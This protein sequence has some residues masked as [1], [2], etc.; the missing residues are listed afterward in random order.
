MLA[1][2]LLALAA[3]HAACPTRPG[4]VLELLGRVETGGLTGKLAR[5]VEAATGRSFE[6]HDLGIV[7]TRT[8]FDGRL[9]WSQD[10]SGGV[11][12][13]NSAFGRR[14]AASMAWLDGRVGCSPSQRDGITRLG[15]RTE[16]K[17]R[18]YAWKAGP[19]GGVPFELWY[20][21][22][23]GRLDRPFFQ[24]AETRLIRHF[25][26]WRSV[27]G[28]L[29]PFLQRDEFPEDEDEVV[30]RI[31]HA[32]I[33]KT[34]GPADFVRP[35]PPSDARILGHV[36]F[37]TVPFEDDHRTRIYLPVT[38]NGK[39]PFLFELDNGG[40]NILTSETAAALGLQKTGSFNATGAGTAVAQSG[41]ARVTRVQIGNAVVTD[42]PFSVREFSA[43][44]NDRSP[45][46]PRAGV[47]GL[48]LF[49]RFVIAI[50]P[51][52]K[53]V[54]L[55][56]FDTID[57][58]ATAPIPLVFTEDAPLIEGSYDGEP[59]D[60]MLDTGNAGPTIIEDYWA[61]PRGLTTEL[62]KGVARGATKV[63]H[64][65]VGVGPFDLNDELVSYYGPAERGSEYSRAVAGIY[66]EPLLSRFKS[67]YDY[68]GGVVWLEPLPEVKPQPFDRS[69]LSLAKA[70]GGA[71]KVAPVAGGS[72]AQKAGIAKDD[73]IGA[74][75]GIPSTKLSRA[76]AAAIFR[77]EPG[78][79][80][81][82]T[83]TFGGAQGLKQL[84]LAEL[85]SR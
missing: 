43:A 53:T 22:R 49:E 85:I 60:F 3:A 16:G 84:T 68:S 73:L 17:R 67:T 5:R 1:A 56:R 69:G 80:V 63:T 37:T 29:V 58:P 51:R 4:E 9:A 77:G 62:N 71:L 27:D 38:L 31:T 23:G 70:E 34:A 55:S 12:D 48:E 8:G 72:P 15:V 25:A 40:H 50:D 66:G 44:S 35:R 52:A 41:T 26:D 47:L 10:G 45:N 42:Q 74:I 21:L 18:F 61:V 7:V 33:R 83:G 2:A 30:R 39:G 75:Q 79:A 46:P 19:P 76:D 36:A 64:G 11:H 6:V 82:L 32:T 57:R 24:M 78:M 28:R 81:M 14:L 20:D 13:L 54:T 59:G 65:S